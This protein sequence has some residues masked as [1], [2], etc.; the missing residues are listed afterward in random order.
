MAFSWEDQGKTVGPRNFNYTTQV[1]GN[2]TTPKVCPARIS[3]VDSI[4]IHSVS[5]QFAAFMAQYNVTY[6][7]LYNISNNTAFARQ[8]NTETFPTDPAFNGSMFI[9][10]TDVGFLTTKGLLENT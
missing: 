5:P 9:A 3:I 6:S 4:H 1:G 7:P 2:S 10:L 8:P